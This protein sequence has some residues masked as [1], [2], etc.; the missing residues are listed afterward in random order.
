M[1]GDGGEGVDACS[2]EDSFGE[3][4]EVV[5]ICEDELY[6]TEEDQRK[7]KKNTTVGKEGRKERT[8]L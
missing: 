8:G 5:E 7:G 6:N 3:A 2:V 1:N 4:G